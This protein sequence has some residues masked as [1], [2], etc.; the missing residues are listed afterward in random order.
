[1]S[2]RSRIILGFLLAII[3]TAASTVFLAA[4]QIRGDVDDY[5]NATAKRQ[6]DLLDN[7]LAGFIEDVKSNVAVL[8][9]TAGLAE[10]RPNM[11]L[12]KDNASP[13][14]FV[15][16]ELKGAAAEAIRVLSSMS[17]RHK[18]YVEVYAGYPDGRFATSIDGSTV[19]ANY[20]SSKRSWYLRG[21][22][23]SSD[24]TYVDAYLSTS[25]ETV[26]A[27]VGKVRDASGKFI[28]TVGIDVTLKN[29]AEMMHKLNFGKT[30]SF[31]LIEQTGRILCDPKKSAN[32][33]K[34]IGTDTSDPAL[35]TMKNA[36]DGPLNLDYGGTPMRA[37]VRT[38]TC[39]WKMI[40][41]QAEEEIVAHSREAI[42]RMLGIACIVALLLIGVGM[43]IARSINRPLNKLVVAMDA[44]A[45]GDFKAVPDRPGFYKELLTLRNALSKMVKA[46]VHSLALAQKK[47]KEAEKAMATAQEATK[48]AE[49]AAR[50]AEAAKSEGMHT[51]AEQLE[52]MVSAISAAASQLSV[53]IEESDKGA[54]ESS[55][56]L[57][58]AATAMNEMNATVQEVA[59]NA[60]TT[61]SVSSETRGNAEEGQKILSNAIASI[62]DVQKVSLIL[63]EDMSTLHEHTQNI[64]QI[65]NVISDIADQTNLLALNAAIEAAR[66][67]E[68]GRGF[69]VVAD[70][71]RKLAEKTMV[72]TNDV[73]NAITAIQGSAQ[74]SVNRMEEALDGVEKAT[75]LAQQSGEALQR[76]VQNVE[77]T[78]DQVRAIAT[79][80]EEQ[81]AA[82]E[83]IN[84]SITSVNEMSSRTAQAMN[85]A[86]RAITD[87]AQQTERLTSLIDEMKR[88]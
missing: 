63:K 67:G 13:S 37:M 36:P 22:D 39:G 25:G 48:Q 85:E 17:Q 73:A 57:G 12:F 5:F 15:H 30:G 59:H 18:E 70:E 77:D 4:W 64:S 40:A 81:S 19:P 79:A 53:R 24:I 16:A 58:E 10:A 45:G 26:F 43:L 46:N 74:K 23:S 8:A 32:T 31:L 51:A 29:L 6:L 35:V 54:V 75:A 76:I 86:A 71:V 83:E 20:D 27:A 14:R 78:A 72:S 34:I 60:S 82:S 56:R 2:I 3:L 66:A 84:Q 38:A 61:A 68:A 11:P 28:A 1:M 47:S 50:R 80:S 21:R 52:A 44:V 55:Q 88:A 69:A 49:E 7:H 87:L 9:D 41:L 33:G 42:I 62:N 65:M